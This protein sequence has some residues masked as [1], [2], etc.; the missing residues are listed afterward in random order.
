M[1]GE[2]HPVAWPIIDPEFRNAF[3]DWPNISKVAER[4]MPDA[5]VD[6]D[7]RTLIFKRLKPLMI[8]VRFPN[9][10]HLYILYPRGYIMSRGTL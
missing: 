5:D 7:F 8:D 6:P 9:F 3:A 2:I 1:L 10:D 4:N